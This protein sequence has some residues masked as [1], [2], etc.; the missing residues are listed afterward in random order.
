MTGGTTIASPAVQQA[1]DRSSPVRV[2]VAGR[3]GTVNLPSLHAALVA[4]SAAYGVV[5]DRHRDRHLTDLCALLSVVER[6]DGLESSSSRDLEH[7][8]NAFGVLSRRP[9]IVGRVDGAEAGLLRA[10]ELIRFARMRL[11]RGAADGP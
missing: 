10:R 7:L 8:S 6:G 4:K 3:A 9:E 2:V 11:D 5:L 1:L